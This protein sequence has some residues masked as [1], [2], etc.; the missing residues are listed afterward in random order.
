MSLPVNLLAKN[1]PLVLQTVREVQLRSNTVDQSHG[2][3][4]K[5]DNF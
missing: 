4:E 1:P 5:T 3:D 2:R